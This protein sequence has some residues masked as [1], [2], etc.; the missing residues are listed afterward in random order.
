MRLRLRQRRDDARPRH[1]C[2]C[3]GV[4][5]RRPLRRDPVHG[6]LRAGNGRHGRIARRARLQ[7]VRDAVRPVGGGVV[8]IAAA[9]HLVQARRALRARHAGHAGDYGRREG[10]RH[11]GEREALGVVGHGTAG[12]GNGD[13]LEK[14]A[15]DISS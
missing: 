7:R 9:S 5:A 4:T 3:E 6:D 12:G 8:A 11:A 14:A 1:P 2:L 13:H 10:A 15:S